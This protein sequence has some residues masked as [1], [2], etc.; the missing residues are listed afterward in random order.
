MTRLIVFALIA[1]G[2]YMLFKR[3]QA[4]A[5]MNVKD[6]AKLLGVAANADAE[7]I[8]AAHRRLIAKVHPDSGGS[9]GLASQINAARDLLLRR[10]NP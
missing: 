2:L 6:A 5:A 4:P 1:A 7:A 10:L 9:E 8:N 3:M